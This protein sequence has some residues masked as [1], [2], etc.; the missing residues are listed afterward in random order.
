M[1]DEVE[2]KITA[3]FILDSNGFNDSLQGV[4]SGLRTAQGELGKAKASTEA[5][6]KSSDNLKT[7]QKALGEQVELHSKKV[8]ILKESL[9]ATTVKMNANVKERDRLKNSLQDANITYADTISIYGKESAESKKAKEEVT[10]L[11]NELKNKESALKTNAKA[12]ENNTASLSKA[13]IELIKTQGELQRTN[14]AIATNESKWIAAGKTFEDT[15]K[16]MKTIGDGM[17]GVGNKMTLGLTVPIVGLGVA[18]GKMSMD[19]EDNMAKVGTISN[20][21][22]VP[23]E[24][25][26]KAILKLLQDTCRSTGMTVIIITHNLA[27]TPIGDK[28]IKMKNG[29]IESFTTNDNPT[30]LERIDW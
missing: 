15:S 4:N 9:Q 30:P 24:E 6:G 16:K 3:K 7:V 18:M 21:A 23:I 26:G 13:E 28:I 29:L 17:S 19:F 25:L 14:K 10:K 5:F 11:T 8:N 20:D 1:S 22:E 27:I 12:I 2:K